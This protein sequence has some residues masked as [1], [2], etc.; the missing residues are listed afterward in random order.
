MGSIVSEGEDKLNIDNGY[1]TRKS[2]EV[3][4]KKAWQAYEKTVPKIIKDTKEEH[5]GRYWYLTTMTLP[6]GIL[7]PHGLEY[8]PWRDSGLEK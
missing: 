2:F 6:A 8:K 4:N 3:D 5:K 1:F 7:F